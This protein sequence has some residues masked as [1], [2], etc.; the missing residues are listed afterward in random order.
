MVLYQQNLEWLVGNGFRKEYSHEA[1][2]SGKYCDYFSKTEEDCGIKLYYHDGSVKGNW[3]G[4]MFSWQQCN[5]PDL[6]EKIEHF[7]KTT[8]IADYDD[9]VEAL[10]KEITAVMRKLLKDKSIHPTAAYASVEQDGRTN[11]QVEIKG[12]KANEVY[13]NLQKL[14]QVFYPK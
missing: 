10:D 12:K 4:T 13:D 14:S 6:L 2:T 8:T 5:R 9:K 3:T 1:D 7:R 11:L